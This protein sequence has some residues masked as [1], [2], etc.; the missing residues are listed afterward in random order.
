MEHAKA[1]KDRDIKA[2]CD[3]ISNYCETHICASLS[4]QHVRSFYTFF[5]TLLD[6]L[7]GSPTKRGFMQTQLEPHQDEALKNLLSI[8]GP[9]FQSLLRIS[10]SSDYYYDLSNES[11]PSEVRKILSTGAIH[12]LP[13]VYKH[14]NVI[15][16]SSPSGSIIDFHTS[17]TKQSSLLPSGISSERKIQL[18]ILQLYLYNFAIL[19]TWSTA[20]AQSPMSTFT[21]TPLRSPMNKTAPNTSTIS[22]LDSSSPPQLTKPGRSITSSIYTDVL[23]NY[24]S[25]LIPINDRAF[26]AIV[27]PFFIDALTELWIRMPWITNNNRLSPTLMYYISHFINYIIIELWC[28]WAAPWKLGTPFRSI[29]KESFLPTQTDWAPFILDNVPYYFSA[30]D[31]LLKRISTFSYT[32]SLTMSVAGQLRIL[33]RFINV[34][35][36]ARDLIGFLALVEKALDHAGHAFIEWDQEIAKIAYGHTSAAVKVKEK[37]KAASERLTQIEGKTSQWRSEHL[38]DTEEQQER[39]SPSLI[40]AV[41]NLYHNINIHVAASKWPTRLS[42]RHL[43]PMQ[44]AYRVLSTLFNINSALFAPLKTTSAIPEKRT[45]FT[46]LTFA[47]KQNGG[48]L[49]AEEKELLKQGKLVCS[50][51]NIPAVGP[52]KHTVV[53]SHENVTLVRWTLYWD[54]QLNEMVCAAQ[55]F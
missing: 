41:S 53:R 16:P 35:Y 10:Q 49:T 15:M 51:H 43:E 33:Y 24:L 29:E 26:P 27:G 45:G 23:D 1:I 50:P 34:F 22:F 13:Q 52:R 30:V 11:L 42:N 17:A 25:R 8:Q 48:Y 55:L 20:T 4:T 6:L 54:K 2:I 44:E 3:Y 39:R 5:P 47:G 12:L 37:I 21:S 14:C 18:N 9:F 40:A 38:Y 46:Q 28:Q 19:P 36:T 32:D 7:F 31:I